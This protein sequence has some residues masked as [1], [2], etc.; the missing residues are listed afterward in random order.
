MVVT[1]RR[2]E[3]DWSESI[4][5]EEIQPFFRCAL[6][7]VGEHSVTRTLPSGGTPSFPLATTM[8]T[9]ALG[10]ALHISM[11]SEEVVGGRR[12]KMRRDG[13]VGG[14]MEG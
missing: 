14:G 8:T 1:M 13:V 5:K 3:E 7:R 12:G 11:L 2:T 10:G 6:N 4:R 9:S